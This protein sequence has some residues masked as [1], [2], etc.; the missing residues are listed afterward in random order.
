M[1]RRI[2]LFI[3]LLWLVMTRRIGLFIELLWLYNMVC[4]IHIC[5]IREILSIS[6]VGF[7]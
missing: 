2:D 7:G 5:Q 6:R 4:N 3:E 1:T